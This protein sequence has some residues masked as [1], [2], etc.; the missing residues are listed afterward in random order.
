MEI[1][2]IQPTCSKSL[3][4]LGMW[5]EMTQLTGNEN[6]TDG[7]QMGVDAAMTDFRMMDL[8]LSLFRV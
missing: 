1:G 2:I 3:S 6:Q 5:D 8:L 7:E 4:C